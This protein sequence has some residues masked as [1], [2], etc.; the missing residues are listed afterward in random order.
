MKCLIQNQIV[1]KVNDLNLDTAYQIK[2]A[3]S[4][5]YDVRDLP[6]HIVIS[7][8]NED[9]WEHVHEI[10]SI[11]CRIIEENKGAGGFM[12]TNA[13]QGIGSDT[14]TINLTKDGVIPYPE[15]QI[16]RLV[17]KLSEQWGVTRDKPELLTVTLGDKGTIGGN[18]A[19][20]SRVSS[21]II[22]TPSSYI[23]NRVIASFCNESDQ[24]ASQH[25][26]NE[27]RAMRERYAFV[28]DTLNPNNPNKFSNRIE[29]D[30]IKQSSYMADSVVATVGEDEYCNGCYANRIGTLVGVRLRK[31]WEETLS[32]EARLAKMEQARAAGYDDVEGVVYKALFD[33]HYFSIKAD[34]SN[35]NDAQITEYVF[36]VEKELDENA[37][38]VNLD[39]IEQKAFQLDI[40]SPKS[41]QTIQ[42]TIDVMATELWAAVKKEAWNGYESKIAEIDSTVFSNIVIAA[43]KMITRINSPMD[44]YDDLI[45]AGARRVKIGS[46]YYPA[47]PIYYRVKCRDTNEVFNITIDIP[48]KQNLAAIF[49]YRIIEQRYAGKTMTV[50][51]FAELANEEYQKL[52]RF[53]IRTVNR[54]NPN[55]QPANNGEQQPKKDK[56]RKDKK[57]DRKETGAPQEAAVEGQ[58]APVEDQEPEDKAIVQYEDDPRTEVQSSVQ[59]TQEVASQEEIEQE[60]LAE[61]QAEPEV[62]ES[63]VVDN[64]QP[65]LDEPPAPPIEDDDDG[66]QSYDDGM[67]PV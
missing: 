65:E 15:P 3:I 56:K 27:L 2:N 4:D 54:V 37:T 28:S 62:E 25:Y 11:V 18:I 6:G 20:V 66:E 17:N 43:P 39:I 51:Q 29:I 34:N 14:V 42:S 10:Y 26:Q 58:N 7:L 60:I 44:C 40:R 22:K 36:E 35:G 63:P 1:V 61:P 5:K 21:A 47:D 38:K 19:K 23:Y 64:G 9:K 24:D 30:R 32:D 8:L 12:P 48:M 52:C 49:A 59:P 31:A 33:V 45:K 46:G 16:Q 55:G 50:E 53:D 57:K 41:I 13:F 67:P